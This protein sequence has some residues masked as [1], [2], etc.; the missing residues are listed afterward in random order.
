M[1][2]NITFLRDTKR[3]VLFIT[4]GLL[5]LSG[6]ATDQLSRAPLTP[7]T[8]WT[9]PQPSSINYVRDFSVQDNFQVAEPYPVP[10]INE[11]HAYQLSELIDMAQMNNPDTRIA[12]QQA[13]QAA[14]AVGM[15][16]AT[17]LPMISASVIG[18]YQKNRTKLPYDQ[19]INTSYN[20]LIPAVGF[21]WLLF[22][23]GQRRA[24]VDIAEKNSFAANVSFNGMHQKLIYDVTNAYFMYGAALSRVNIAQ[25]SLQN[26]QNILD[27]AQARLQS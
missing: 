24:L 9:E 20:A 11:S 19:H 6:C 4:V 18:G 16:E 14:L 13:R 21:Q 3:L 23:F 2:K 12:W 10:N 7:F 25:K 15:T 22:D 17:F 27:A 8:S 1:K 5:S 26:S